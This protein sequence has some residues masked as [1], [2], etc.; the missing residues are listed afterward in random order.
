[1]GAYWGQNYTT[2]GYGFLLDHGSYTALYVVGQDSTYASG[3][4]ASG[5]IVGYYIDAAAG[6]YGFLAIPVP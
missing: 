6:A 2:F 3:I 5:Q 1:V 4:N